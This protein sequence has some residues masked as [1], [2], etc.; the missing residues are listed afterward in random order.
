MLRRRGAFGESGA[1]GLGFA[2]DDATH[3]P[4]VRLALAT[5]AA[6]PAPAECYLLMHRARA[7]LS[8][9]L[10]AHLAAGMRRHLSPDGVAFIVDIE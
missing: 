8:P 2:E 3:E 10:A 1:G 9:S 7:A 5:L 4:L 6:P